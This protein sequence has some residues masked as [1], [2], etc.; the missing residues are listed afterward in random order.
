[1]YEPT[2]INKD[3]YNF[4]EG[5]FI[6]A[7]NEASFG[8][9]VAHKIP[10]F[11]DKTEFGYVGLVIVHPIEFVTSDI[12]RILRQSF[13]LIDNVKLIATFETSGKIFFN[14]NVNDGVLTEVMFTCISDEGV[15]DSTIMNLSYGGFGSII[16]TICAT[17]KLTFD[18]QGLSVTLRYCNDMKRPY[19]KIELTKSPQQVFQFIGL[20]HMDYSRGFSTPEELFEW[21]TTCRL[22]K[23]HIFF[24]RK[25]TSREHRRKSCMKKIYRDFLVWLEN[26]FQGEESEMD[27]GK[28]IFEQWGEVDRVIKCFNKCDEADLMKHTYEYEQEVIKQRKKH[29]KMSKRNF[30]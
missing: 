18:S 12:M 15:L 20:D 26:R 29:L 8:K 16:G 30:N 25:Y 14:I 17:Y 11:R 23:P 10:Q 9:I 7:I 28:N 6:N 24:K 4:I 1:M 22:F 2:F 13:R 19:G 5:V 21:V 3:T 27:D